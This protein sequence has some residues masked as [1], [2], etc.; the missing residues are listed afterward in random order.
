[1]TSVTVS[2][3]DAQTAG[4]NPSRATVNEAGE[5]F[6]VRIGNV[7]VPALS[8]DV[9]DTVAEGAVDVNFSGVHTMV[10]AG[11][12]GMTVTGGPV[13][14]RHGSLYNGTT[15]DDALMVTNVTV[16]VET[17]TNTTTTTGGG[18]GGGGVPTCSSETFTWSGYQGVNK[19]N[20]LYATGVNI[21]VT[22][23]ETWTVTGVSV[24]T[25]D[26]QSPGTTPSRAT[27]DEAGERVGIRIG[28]QDV[29]ALTTDLPDTVGE[30]AVDTNFWGLSL[31][32]SLVGNKPCSP[33]VVPSR[34]AMPRRITVPPR[35]TP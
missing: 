17:C 6:G 23:G 4:T 32:H 33:P 9:P 26:A 18:S 22:A 31:R 7:D 15:G 14:I 24:Q 2:S 8:D 27:L 12:V 25:Y 20:P 30:G 19:N 35:M 28:T 16:I 13:M 10:L 3:Y 21:N 11:W 5:R 1:M 34:S 29:T